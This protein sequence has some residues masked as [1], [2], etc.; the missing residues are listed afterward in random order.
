MS[1][2]T[3]PVPD[4]PGV[5]LADLAIPAGR[6]RP[7]GWI[8]ELN[9]DPSTIAGQLDAQLRPAMAAWRDEF[10]G[11]PSTR[12]LAYWMSGAAGFGHD[13]VAYAETRVALHRR[14]LPSDGG[15]GMSAVIDGRTRA[16]RPWMASTEGA[17][18]AVLAGLDRLRSDRQE[19]QPVRVVSLVE[20]I[21]TIGVLA[22]VHDRYGVPLVSGSGSVP[23]SAVH[24]IAEDAVALWRREAVPTVVLMWTD[25]DMAG[26]RNIFAPV[27]RDLAAFAADW[28]A[29]EAIHVRRIGAT[30]D[31]VLDGVRDALRERAPSN[32]PAWWPTDRN[33]DRWTLATSEVIARQAR[34]AFA[35]A[36]AELLPDEDARAAMVAT[37]DDRRAA[38]RCAIRDE[39]ANDDQLGDLDGYDLPSQPRRFQLGPPISRRIA[40]IVGDLVYGDDSEH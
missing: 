12:W 13:Q 24:D 15:I 3:D 39:L 37:E 8:S 7:K 22:D 35:D 19:G 14:L 18:D 30:P 40:S 28:H 2:L 32:A 34:A 26:L 6:S 31:Q 38:A 27:A 17:A 5:S 1:A 11:R 4:L 23:L 16:E 25:L 10:P 29:P 36:L 20:A 21:G 33:G 9:V